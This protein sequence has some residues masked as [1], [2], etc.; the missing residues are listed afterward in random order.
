VISDA[1]ANPMMQ[2]SGRIDPSGLNH[3]TFP[4]RT[5]VNVAMAAASKPED[6]F[7]VKNGL[8]P[9]VCFIPE[10]RSVSAAAMTDS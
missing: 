8:T 5:D 3:H 1:R 2:K 7:G 10:G 4:N 9:L 6:R